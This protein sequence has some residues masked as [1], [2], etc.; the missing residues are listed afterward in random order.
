MASTCGSVDIAPRIHWIRNQKVILDRDLASLY[1]IATR[2]LKQS[3]RR[4]LRRFPGDFMFQLSDEEVD[5]L[6][7]QTVIPHKRV[8]GGSNPM[9]FTEQGIAML[10]SVLRSIQA[11]EVNIAIMRTFVQLRQ[12]M[13]SNLLLSQKIDDL[14]KKYDER[15]AAV[16]DAIKRLVLQESTRKTEPKRRIGFHP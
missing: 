8:F 13:D 16:F 9:A 12:L 3:V 7:S 10:S 14:E 5:A 2:V 15:F 6:V 4:N 11:I 1:G